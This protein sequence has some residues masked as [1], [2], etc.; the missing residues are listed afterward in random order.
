MFGCIFYPF[1]SL[2]FFKSYWFVQVYRYLLATANIP[3]SHLLICM[4][5]AFRNMQEPRPQCDYKF[6]VFKQE[7]LSSPYFDFSA[8]WRS[9]LPLICTSIVFW[10]VFKITKPRYNNFPPTRNTIFFSIPIETHFMN[11]RM[12]IN[13][14]RNTV[15]HIITIN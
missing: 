11:F 1:Y 8:P 6:F 5:T 13:R 14:R 4:L 2:R 12:F 7:T 10:F 15:T 3:I 9:I